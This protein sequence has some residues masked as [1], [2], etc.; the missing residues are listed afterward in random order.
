MPGW[1]DLNEQR[2]FPLADDAIVDD[3][4]NDV[5]ADLQVTIPDSQPYGV[6]PKLASISIGDSYISLVIEVNGVAVAWYGGDKTTRQV[7]P[8]T[9]LLDGVSGTV[10][11]GDGALNHRLRIDLT[12]G[13][14]AEGTY[15]RYV[16]QKHPHL[17]I[18]KYGSAAI[19][20]DGI[21]DLR[22]DSNLSLDLVTNVTIQT[23]SGP[24]VVPQAIQIGMRAT[25]TSPVRRAIEGHNKRSVAA[26]TCTPRVIN[27]INGVRPD[28]DGRFTLRI[29]GNVVDIIGAPAE[30]RFSSELSATRDC[31]D[32][33]TEDPI[34]IPDPE[35]Q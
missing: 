31:D 32:R 7:L 27:T 6:A 15:Q 22:V 3:L 14:M 12:D 30:V 13:K 29:V 26:G 11:I 35:C 2:R 28:M 34:D 8:L 17:A 19:D 23:G 4:P 16:P 20:M 21:V 24:I 25:V 9:P 18:D 5:I 33:D 10:V 1:F